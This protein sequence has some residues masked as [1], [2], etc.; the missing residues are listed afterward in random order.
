MYF[1]RT[2]P[3]LLSYVFYEDDPEHYTSG[4]AQVFI[5]GDKGFMFGIF[6]KGFFKAFPAD[7]VKFMTAN[8]LSSLEGY[9]SPSNARSVR[10]SF[11]THPEISV[12][13]GEPTHVDGHKVIW[14]TVNKISK[15][16][17]SSVTSFM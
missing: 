17:E 11:R 12:H 8:G 13:L 5:Y 2:I 9:M 16:D 15:G 3:R 14:V 1:S 4:G 7:A 6:G 10:M